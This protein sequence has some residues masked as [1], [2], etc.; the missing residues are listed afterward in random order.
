MDE[1]G[2]ALARGIRD[3]VVQARARGERVDSADALI[4]ELVDAL[5]DSL[6]AA[7]AEAEAALPEGSHVDDLHERTPGLWRASA[8]DGKNWGTF[9]GYSDSPAAALHALA[10]K[11]RERSA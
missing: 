8:P 2:L 6:D 5:P 11:L 1:T 3:Q 9:E 10:E 4:A 7:W